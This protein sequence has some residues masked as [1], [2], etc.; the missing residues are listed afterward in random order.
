MTQFQGP[1]TIP[2]QNQLP[3]ANQSNILQLLQA[4]LAN[5]APQGNV[6]NVPVNMH[7]SSQ[8]SNFLGNPAP[9]V[10]SN[11]NLNTLGLLSSLAG[12]GQQSNSNVKQ[13]ASATQ[14]NQNVSSLPGT[15][16]TNPGFSTYDDVYA[17]SSQTSSAYGP[18]R[19]P[20]R[21][22]PKSSTYRPY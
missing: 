19:T 20:A 14:L 1:G 5:Q 22:D 7:S 4:A 9:N 6:Q 11:T 16:S 2:V 3:N 18:M 10:S 12:I 17:S 21:S 15:P 8:L 13:E